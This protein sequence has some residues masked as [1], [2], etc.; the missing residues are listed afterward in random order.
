[1]RILHAMAGAEHGGAETFFERLVTGLDRAGERQRLAIRRQPARAARLAALGLAPLELG[2]G[3]ALDLMT[4]LRLGREIDRW[5]PDVVLSWMSRA[6]RHCPAPDRRRRFLFVGTPRGYYNPK[7]FRRCDRLVCATEEIA[8][9][10]VRAGWRRDRV[11]VIPNFVPDTRLPAV[12][13]ASLDTPEGVPVLLALGRL[14]PNKAFDVLLA[15]LAELPEHW[16]WLGGEGPLEAELKRQAETLGV[17]RRVRFLGW[18]EDAAALFAAADV[19]VCSSRIE[20]FGNIVVEAWQQ[21]VPV[22]A[23]DV[24]GPARL[25]ADGATGLKVAKDDPGALAAALRRLAA[26]PQLAA[27]LAAAGRRR[28]EEAYTECVVVGAYRAFFARALG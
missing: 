4:R 2:F 20:P 19:F 22:V 3:G 7:Y 16:L 14:H 8:D 9:F 18:R 10:Y 27:A 11:E 13:R 15:A 17:A 25:I 12:A 5:R 26:E 1:M 21:G 24:Q 6:T 23:V 28:Y